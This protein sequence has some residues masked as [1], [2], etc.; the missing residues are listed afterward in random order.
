M[1]TFLDDHVS[2]IH[3]DV[4]VPAAT[5]QPAVRLIDTEPKITAG[6]RSVTHSWL[7]RQGTNDEGRPTRTLA[8]LSTMH[9][10]SRFKGFFSTLNVVTETD[11]D[12][13]G[14]TFTSQ[15]YM[16]FDAITIHS[17]GAPR[18]SAKALSIAGA[19][20]RA[21]LMARKDDD[22]VRKVFGEV[23]DS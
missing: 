8:V 19:N 16:P 15:A 14:R 11:E 9:T 23:E 5:G 13:H 4:P 22:A 12:M 18:Y 2:I 7:V 20:A 6:N 10:N 3:V 21:A 17:E 1:T